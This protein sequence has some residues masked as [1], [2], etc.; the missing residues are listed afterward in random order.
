MCVIYFR[1]VFLVQGRGPSLQFF[2]NGYSVVT[3]LFVENAFHVLLKCLSVFVKING[4]CVDLFLD[5]CLGLLVLINTTALGWQCLCEKQL[6]CPSQGG[7]YFLISVNADHHPSGF[8]TVAHISTACTT[9]L[10]HDFNIEFCR[11]NV[12]CSWMISVFSDI[13]NLVQCIPF[14][15]DLG[16]RIMLKRNMYEGMSEHS[17]QSVPK[18]VNQKGR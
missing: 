15:C 17:L 1:L 6:N 4:T 5:S 14:H 13:K 10:I 12:L 3:S 2:P 18:L 11:W 16:Q 8:L 7:G 9:S